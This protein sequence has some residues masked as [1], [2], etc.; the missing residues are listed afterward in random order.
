M[1]RD[2]GNTGFLLGGGSSRFVLY[3]APPVLYHKTAKG[4]IVAP[5]SIAMIDRS[6]ERQFPIFLAIAACLSMSLQTTGHLSFT[7][8]TTG[9]LWCVEVSLVRASTL[10]TDTAGEGPSCDEYS[11]A[12]SLSVV[13]GLPGTEL[14]QQ[15]R[16]LTIARTSLAEGFS[17][18]IYRPPIATV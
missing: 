13:P 4:V 18:E 12:E 9:T 17:A 10:P 3:F 1:V 7:E 8:P 11:S 16:I 14:S 6:L 15:R 5:G 2:T